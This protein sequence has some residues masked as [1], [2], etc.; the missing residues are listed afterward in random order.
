MQAT[1]YKNE[2]NNSFNY[3]RAGFQ[4]FWL[5]QVFWLCSGEECLCQQHLEIALSKVEFAFFLNLDLAVF[6]VRIWKSFFLKVGL[7][8]FWSLD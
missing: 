8:L 6:D 7:G 3:L 2:N 5:I 4:K 1:I